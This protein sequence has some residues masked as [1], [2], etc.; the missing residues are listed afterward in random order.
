MENRRISYGDS[1]EGRETYPKDRGRRDTP[2]REN[3][4]RQEGLPPQGGHDSNGLGSFVEH[5]V[6]DNR[7]HQSV[8]AR[9]ESEVEV[10]RQQ[11]GI[12]VS[13]MLR[14]SEELVGALGEVSRL[15]AALRDLETMYD[16]SE[17][18]SSADPRGRRHS[19]PC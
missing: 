13:A 8:V 4:H 14:I 15:R 3:P 6:L 1:I 7:R 16:K 19:G 5:D 17:I 10:L 18:E 11:A 2:C 12:T 9:L